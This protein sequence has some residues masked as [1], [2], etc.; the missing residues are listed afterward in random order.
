M[1]AVCMGVEEMGM[2]TRHRGT[3]NLA[4]KSGLRP[5]THAD[6]VEHEKH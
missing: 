6:T 2:Q 1:A 3:Y 4:S 5:G